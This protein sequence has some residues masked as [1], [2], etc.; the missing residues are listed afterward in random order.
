MV[1]CFYVKK[2]LKSSLQIWY[3]VEICKKKM[4]MEEESET[5]A[6]KDLE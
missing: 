4:R 1:K 5:R 3:E 2:Q 6:K